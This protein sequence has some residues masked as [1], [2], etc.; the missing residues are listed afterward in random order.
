MTR[1]VDVVRRIAPRARPTYVAAFERG[2]AL[3]IAR[4]SLGL[5]FGLRLTRLDLSLMARVPAASAPRDVALARAR[6]IMLASFHVVDGSASVWCPR[7]LFVCTEEQWLNAAPPV[8]SSA[9]LG[10]QTRYPLADRS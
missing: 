3:L 8:H 7:K 4:F 5:D 1:A 2:D 10:I 6:R 9:S